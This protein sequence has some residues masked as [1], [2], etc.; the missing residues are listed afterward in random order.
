MAGGGEKAVSSLL[1]DKLLLLLLL[2]L[3]VKVLNVRLALEVSLDLE[4]LP[5]GAMQGGST[6]ICRVS[7]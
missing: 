3:L 4:V 1:V 7:S 6:L 5:P 2:L